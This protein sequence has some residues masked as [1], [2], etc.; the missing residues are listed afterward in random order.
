M[1]ISKCSLYEIG[2]I[3]IYT[4]VMF[5]TLLPTLHQH[6]FIYVDADS[7][8]FFGIITLI[9]GL[10]FYFFSQEYAKEQLISTAL[11]VNS[12]SKMIGYSNTQ[13]FISKFKTRYGTTPNKYRIK[14]K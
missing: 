13:Y 2:S 5:L 7:Y 9:S 11:P 14:N 4:G 10:F 6:H 1:K 8:K 3:C 12:I